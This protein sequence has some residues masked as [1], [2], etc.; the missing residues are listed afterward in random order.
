MAAKAFEDIKGRNKNLKMTGKTVDGKE[1]TLTINGKDVK[2]TVDM[3]IG[4][5]TKSDNQEDIKKL[6]GRSVYTSL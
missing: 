3:K 4:V 1:Y 6:A 5:T 2:K